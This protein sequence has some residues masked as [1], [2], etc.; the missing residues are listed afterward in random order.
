MRSDSTVAHA[1][2]LAGLDDVTTDG[3]APQV[4][5]TRPE[6]VAHSHQPL[7]NTAANPTHGVLGRVPGGYATRCPGNRRDTVI[8]EEDRC[9]TSWN[10]ADGGRTDQG[11]PVGA[12]DAEEDR[13]RAAHDD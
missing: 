7:L 1:D 12:A 9:L 4:T 2:R 11:V 8:T 5:V 13:R 3:D 10:R 6:R